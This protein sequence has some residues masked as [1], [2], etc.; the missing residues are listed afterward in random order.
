MLREGLLDRRADGIR[1][2]VLEPPAVFGDLALLRD[3]PRVATLSALSPAV[4]WRLPADRF[5]RLLS[6]TPGIA[7]FS[8]PTSSTPLP[9]AK[10][11]ATG[12]GRAPQGIPRHPSSTATR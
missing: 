5:T 7:A 12:Q 4:L 9:S 2:A 10:K 8:P 3:E 1:L 6:R 11:R